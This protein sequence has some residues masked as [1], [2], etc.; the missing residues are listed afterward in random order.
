MN[1]EPEEH[2]VGIDIARKHRF[3]VELEK[4]LARKRL[5]V[6]QDAQ[7]Q[8]I[9][10]DRPQVSVAAVEKLLYEAVRVGGGRAALP[11]RSAV[12]REAAADE[13]H[14]H[15]TEETPDGIGAAGDLRSGGRRQKTEPQLAQQRQTPFVVGEA[16]ARLAFR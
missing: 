12:E 5:V 9:R 16:G 15:R 11:R 6:P 2:E 7:A 13:M 3:E 4:R 10:D 14:R 1:D 8:T